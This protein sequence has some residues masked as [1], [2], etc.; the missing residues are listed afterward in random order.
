MKVSHNNRFLVNQDGSPFFWLGDTAWELF[1]RLNRSDTEHYLKNRSAKGFNVIQ[2]VLPGLI[3][4][5]V[6]NQGGELIFDDM[7]PSRPNEK[8]FEHADWVIDKANEL[9]VNLAILPLWGRQIEEDHPDVKN[10]KIFDQES[11]YSYGNYLGNR[12]KDRTNIV[13]ILGGDAT[14]A[15][16]EQLWENLAKGIKAGG[17]TH[18]IS[19]HI[20]GE[21]S[22]SEFWHTAD[23]LDFNMIQ[24]GHISAFYD[25]YRLIG[26][27]Y[28]LCPPKPVLDGEP[29]YEGIA[30][31]FA[32]A[33][34]NASDH[35]VRVEAYWS[36]FS[37]GFGFTYGHNSIWQMY[38]GDK[39]PLFLA[40]L[41]WKE[42]ME[43]PGG[44]QMQVLKN[45]ML[46]RPF[47]A[48]I[49]DQSILVP[50]AS[51]GVDHLQATRDGTPGEKD[52]TYIMVYFPFMTHKYKI[53][54]DVISASELRS[55]WYDPRT[56][57]SFAYGETDNTGS[58][59]M[60]WGCNINTN[61]GGPDW[62]LV[63][64]DRSKNYPPPGV[65]LRSVN[66]QLVSSR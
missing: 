13:W 4:L 9:G 43:A 3:G 1:H 33:N 5:D 28:D 51:H 32:S 64:D 16:Y 7:D 2:C 6:P 22:S 56:G 40:D 54:T 35:H 62:I 45:L 24:S 19:Y 52:A 37:G 21:R 53:K 39:T 11:I 38:D 42:A 66:V 8:V 12:Y 29:I 50:E 25:N 31:G 60:P 46:S 63:I 18:L 14:P 49:P 17:S 41:P 23:W 61:D 47:L 26:R 65:P 55:W 59:E 30:V 44:S 34:G 57:A 48:R 36:I 20:F 58:F 27:D 15:G 10:R